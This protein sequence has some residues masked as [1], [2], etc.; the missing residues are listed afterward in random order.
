MCYT[1]FLTNRLY[2]EPLM[3][4]KGPFFWSLTLAAAAVRQH[5][6]LFNFDFPTAAGS[7]DWNASKGVTGGRK[8]R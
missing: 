6:N 5:S 4:S 3:F 1:F 2:F 7:K 8:R